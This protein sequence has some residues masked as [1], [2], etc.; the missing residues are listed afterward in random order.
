MSRARRVISA[1][2]TKFD[3]AYRFSA[4]RTRSASS[5]LKA[6]KHKRIHPHTSVMRSRIMST[7]GSRHT[8]PEKAVRSALHRKG[9]RFRLHYSALP[10]S[11]DIVL[12]CYRL[13]IFING[14]F[15][16]QHNGCKK[17]V[18][19]KSNV[20]FWSEKLRSTQLRD[21]KARNALLSLGWRVITLWEC[22]ITRDLSSQIRRIENLTSCN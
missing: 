8:K 6:M 11:P 12:P 5:R 21:A 20:A 1:R 7:I 13:A 10:G 22:A 18:M 14:C 15:W 3:K 19:P 4:S 17:A 9:F 16:H 2:S